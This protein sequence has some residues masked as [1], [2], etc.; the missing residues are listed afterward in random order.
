[1]TAPAASSQTSHLQLVSASQITLYRE[2]PR[3]WAWRYLQGIKTETHP[4]AALGTE[5][6]DT[7]LQPFLRDGRPFDFTRPSGE[8]A[9][10]LLGFL[11]EPKSPGLVV[12]RYFQMP[13]PT[14]R[15]GK[16]IG[17]GFQGFEDL[18]LPDSKAVPGLPGGAPFVGDFKTTS[19]LKWAKNEE[20]LK[21]DVQAMTYATDAMFSTGARTVDLAWMYAQTKGPRRSKRTYLRVVADHVAEQFG[22]INETAIEMLGVRIANP[23]PSELEPNPDVCKAYGGC[24]YESRCA[25]SPAQIISAHS[26]K[27]ARALGLEKEPMSGTSA[28]L[29]R[30]QQR[31]GQQPTAAGPATAAPVA[32]TTPAV[33]PAAAQ[34]SG[35]S[36]AAGSNPAQP[37]PVATQAEL[38]AH[39]AQNP[40]ASFLLEQAPLVIV[41]VNPP[42]SKLPDAPPVG[43]TQA[44]EAPKR[45]GRPPKVQ[46]DPKGADAA[47]HAGLP[48][49]PAPPLSKMI[50][51]GDPIPVPTGF[52]TAELVNVARAVRAAADAF[53][54]AMG[55]S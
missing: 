42:E 47:L 51:P 38:A 5:V 4:A 29:A 24:P 55:A 40:R 19:D 14:W 28:L 41:G 12:Q 17:F 8:I 6:D 50:Y 26:A 22:Q 11:P 2:C 32:P 34:I 39:V 54:V 49:P 10:S 33:A 43:Q 23:H 7:Q 35:A 37:P 20:A 30:L 36:L 53:L 16:H 1:M 27:A 48:T 3:K 9:A 46:P 13:S 18:W 21:T 44:T 45:R 15:D 52:S 25:L 31:S